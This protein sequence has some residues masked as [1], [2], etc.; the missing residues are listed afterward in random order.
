MVK[1]VVE[2]GLKMVGG[3]LYSSVNI[4]EATMAVKLATPVCLLADLV[5]DK[6]AKSLYLTNV[7]YMSHSWTQ[8]SKDINMKDFGYNLG[9]LASLIA[10]GFAI[11]AIVTRVIAIT[12]RIRNP[13]ERDE[14]RAEIQAWRQR[15]VARVM[16]GSPQT[17]M[18]GLRCSICR[19]ASKSVINLP[20]RHITYCRPCFEAMRDNRR[21]SD[22]DRPINS[23]EFFFF[24]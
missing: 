15:M 1:S 4:N 7:K 21:C 10:A 3:S 22:C 20:C 23:Q 18:K 8:L 6:E 19:D 16:N 11:K 14:H 17:R 12:Q 5:F 13:E 24:N 2:E 9:Y